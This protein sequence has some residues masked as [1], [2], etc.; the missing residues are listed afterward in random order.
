VTL[1]PILRANY[2]INSCEKIQTID[3]YE[4]GDTHP[5]NSYDYYDQFNSIKIVCFFDA[6]SCENFSCSRIS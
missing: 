2:R 4:S 1:L 3:S 5:T 6:I